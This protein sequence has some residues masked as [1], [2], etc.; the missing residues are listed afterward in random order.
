MPKGLSFFDPIIRHEVK[1]ALEAGG[2]AYFSQNS[3][4]TKNGLFIYDGYEAT[5]T[6]FTKSREVFDHFYGLKPSSYIFS[7]LEV[8]ELPKEVW[9]IWQL[10]VDK[11]P[12][13]HRFKHFVSMDYN[14]R[15][16]EQFMAATQPE[17]NR[18]WVGVALTNGDRCFVVKIADR[19]VG[20]AWMTIVGG[21][22]RSHGLYVEP[23]FR[24][25]GIMRDNLQARLIYLKSRHV[26]TLINEI[27][28]SNVASYSHAAR[29][30]E[31]IVGKIFLYTSPDH[32]TPS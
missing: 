12:S 17:T 18:R 10:D 19:I 23:Q 26:H 22:A 16:L 27:A 14:V 29:A 8:A 20:I 1:E 30:G 21:V 15:E 32:G 2:E 24:R 9:N 13:G 4:G 11:A 3:E 31:K 6:I 28:E 5:G 7:E 25:L